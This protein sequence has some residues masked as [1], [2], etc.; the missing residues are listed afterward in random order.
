MEFIKTTIAQ[1][2]V[3]IF[4]KSYCP[5]C[6]KAVRFI[7]N[8]TKG[9]YLNID[10]DKY[11]GSKVLKCRREDGPVIQAALYEMTGRRTVPNVFIHGKSVGGG[12]DTERLFYSGELAE[13]VRDI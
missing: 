7:S 12:D 10:L 5:F 4:G 1:N 8:V 11:V 3:V 6:I 2:P 9:K 13:M